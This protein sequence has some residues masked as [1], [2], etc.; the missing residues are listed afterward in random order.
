[1]DAYIELMKQVLTRLA[2]ILGVAGCGQFEVLQSKGQPAEDETGAQEAET[3]RPPTRPDSVN[4]AVKPPPPAAR[5]AEQFDTTTTEQ[6]EAAAKVTPA[7]SGEIDL[8]LTIASLGSPTEAGFWLKT[9]LV[10]A[11]GRGRVEFPGTGNSVQVDLIPI[12][13]MEGAGSRL[14]LAAMRVIEAP[15]TGLPEVRVFLLKD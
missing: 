9:P 7:A 12:D 4:A 14:S 3:P 15:L 8:G 1:M 6:R 11:A 13:G 2:L 10:D 5:T